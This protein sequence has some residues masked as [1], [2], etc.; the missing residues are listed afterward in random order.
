VVH[1][2]T[3]SDRNC[4][5]QYVTTHCT[6][7]LATAAHMHAEWLICSLHLPAA[8]SCTAVDSSLLLLQQRLAGLRSEHSKTQTCHLFIGNDTNMPTF[9]CLDPAKQSIAVM[10][11]EQSL[12]ALH[13]HRILLHIAGLWCYTWFPQSI[14]ISTTL[15]GQWQNQV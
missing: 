1:S 5:Q 14:G 15:H 3:T 12:H 11:F 7:Q 2:P 6:L 4:L 13:Q 8:Y 9:F 10:I